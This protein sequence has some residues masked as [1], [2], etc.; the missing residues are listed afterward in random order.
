MESSGALHLAVAKEA[1]GVQYGVKEGSEWH[2]EMAWDKQVLLTALFDLQ[3][4][5]AG[6]PHLASWDSESETLQY[7]VRGQDA[8]VTELL[9]VVPNL[10]QVALALDADGTPHVQY[11][12]EDPSLLDAPSEIYWAGRDTQGWQV[13][14][15]D[16]STQYPY[17]FKFHHSHLALSPDGLPH[18]AYASWEGVRHAF[19]NADGQWSVEL[20]DEPGLEVKGNKDLGLGVDGQGRVHMAYH[21]EARVFGVGFLRYCVKDATGWEC[22]TLDDEG[23]AMGHYISLAAGQD[24]TVY[25]SYQDAINRELRVAELHP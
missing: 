5:G 16:T 2:F 18:V 4:D 21:Q 10:R 1:G 17:N 15:V 22:R 24:G 25:V 19:R 8:W 7:V 23:P 3:V 6:Q 13:E 11:H 12:T 14:R 20:V 9:R